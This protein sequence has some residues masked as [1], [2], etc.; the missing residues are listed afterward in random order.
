MNFQQKRHFNKTRSAWIHDQSTQFLLPPEKS[1]LTYQHL[2][3]SSRVLTPAKKH[4]LAKYPPEVDVFKKAFFE[5]QPVPSPAKDL[6]T[7]LPKHKRLTG[8][9]PSCRLDVSVET[10]APQGADGN[11][12]PQDYGKYRNYG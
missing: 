5:V 8:G 11:R 10:H 3:N 12:V 1:R 7:I 9:L 4:S 6:G 2:E